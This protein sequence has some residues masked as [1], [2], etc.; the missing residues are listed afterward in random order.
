MNQK[1][2]I[3]F[4]KYNMVTT[5]ITLPFMLGQAPLCWAISELERE[6]KDDFCLFGIGL[7]GSCWKVFFGS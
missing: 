3:P 4:Y 5:Y 6:D 2:V 1:L 7:I